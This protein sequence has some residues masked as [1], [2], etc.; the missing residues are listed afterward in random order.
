MRINK[1]HERREKSTDG[2]YK[3]RRELYELRYISPLL[4]KNSP[5]P[6]DTNHY[7]RSS[8]LS[9]FRVRS[10]NLT[11]HETTKQS[12]VSVSNSIYRSLLMYIKLINVFRCWR[13]FEYRNIGIFYIDTRFVLLFVN[14]INAFFL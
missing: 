4:Q 2:S 5:Y 8:L 6:R 11:L 13:H 3:K 7:E 12:P 14:R 10:S 1:R 9:S